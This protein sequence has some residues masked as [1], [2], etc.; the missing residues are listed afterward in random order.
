MRTT[1]GAGRSA[2]VWVR[3]DRGDKSVSPLA[4]TLQT[5]NTKKLYKRGSQISTA[6]SSDSLESSN[7]NSLE[8]PIE[9]HEQ[10]CILVCLFI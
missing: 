2:S 1:P 7:R 10:A 8:S 6:S 5:K 9:L 3:A 4:K